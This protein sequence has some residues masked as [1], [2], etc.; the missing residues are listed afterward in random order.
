MTP[1]VDPAAPEGPVSVTRTLIR[2]V[3]QNSQLVPLVIL[4]R[5]LCPETGNLG[6]F[7]DWDRVYN[8]PPEIRGP[9]NNI[10]LRQRLVKPGVS[11]GSKDSWP[12]FELRFLGVPD[13]RVLAPCEKRPVT[14]VA[15]G[16]EADVLVDMLGCVFQFEYVRKGVRYRTRQGYTIDV[17]EVYKL[18]KRHDPSNELLAP[19]IEEGANG[20]R[21][22]GVVEIVSEEG[23]SPEELTAFMQH[24]HPWVTLK[25]PQQRKV[26][27]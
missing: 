27:R 26:M 1:S 2:G 8:T 16:K 19:L 18:Q 17:Y 6:E 4:I 15:M 10:R 13:R 12:A 23:A 20:Q 11:P 21:Q 14:T 5:S 25:G 22:P 3:F 24:L 9:K 7:R